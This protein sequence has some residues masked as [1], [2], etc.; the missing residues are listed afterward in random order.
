MGYTVK[1]NGWITFRAGAPVKAL[2]KE[3]AGVFEDIGA[4]YCTKGGV[5][6]ITIHHDG[7][8]DD[9]QAISI[10][11]KMNAHTAGGEIELRGQEDD[12]WRYR[13][14]QDKWVCETGRIIYETFRET[15]S[16]GI[17]YVS[18]D[19]LVYVLKKK[20]GKGEN[21][22][23]FDDLDTAERFRDTYGYRKDSFEIC[24]VPLRF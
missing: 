17:H 11:G 1:G 6:E 2:R 21:I 9:S 23:A 10:L 19:P 22:M 7:N 20:D 4:P 14:V 12:L 24:P 16:E 3:L 13:F 8:L 5:I 15:D 18:Y